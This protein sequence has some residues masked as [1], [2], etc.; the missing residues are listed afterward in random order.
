M[1]NTPS[2]HYGG[3][4][5]KGEDNRRFLLIGNSRWHWA[6]EQADCWHFLHTAPDPQT[7]ESLKIPLISWAA[8]GHIPKEIVLNPCKRLEIKDIPL[9]QLPAWLGIDR[10]LGGWGALKKAES[11]GIHSAGLL[12]ADAGTI[13]SLTRITA[14]GEFAGGQLIPGL[15]LQ[16]S[17]M[18]NGT[19][20]LNNP[21]PASTNSSQ[22]PF[23]TAEA[24]QRGVLQSLIGALIEAVKETNMPLWL[25]GGDAPLLMKEL[26]KRNINAF[27]HPNLV[28]EAMVDIH[29]QINQEQDL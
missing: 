22:F 26:K 13:L 27:H 25:C 23:T 12:V 6:I 24:M 7:I 4:H 3:R 29:R 17:A 14:N 1:W 2:R 11:A 5:L 20:N 15:N 9:K 10:A 19:K 21:G 28:L 8:V 18:A 16:L